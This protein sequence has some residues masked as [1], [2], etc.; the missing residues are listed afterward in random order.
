MRDAELAAT[1]PILRRHT[2]LVLIDRI[3]RTSAR[4]I[5]YARTLTPDDLR[6]VHIA[7]DEV[8]ANELAEQW[9]RLAL[10][11]CPLEIR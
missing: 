5:Q 4:A 7:V 3:D 1:A 2:V 10:A 11:R 8:H 9:S 6:A